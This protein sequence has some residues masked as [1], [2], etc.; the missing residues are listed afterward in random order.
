MW[1]RLG[2]HKWQH[3]SMCAAL[4]V[5]APQALTYCYDYD[6][7][8]QLLFKSYKVIL[9]LQHAAWEKETNN[10]ATTK[11]INKRQKILY[12]A[13]LEVAACVYTCTHTYANNHITH[14]RP[15]C[16]WWAQNNKKRKKAREGEGDGEESRATK[17][18]KSNLKRQ[19][20]PADKMLPCHALFHNVKFIYFAAAA[21]SRTI[22]LLSCCALPQPA[23]YCLLLGLRLRLWLILHLSLLPSPLLH[24]YY[25]CAY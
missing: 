9:S 7:L 12:M 23:E 5:L 13:A 16:C 1:L 21:V 11:K 18:D 22:R 2:L 17:P 4:D 6:F 8:I 3:M 19:L 10:K 25:Y 15:P 24:L 14:T 20:S